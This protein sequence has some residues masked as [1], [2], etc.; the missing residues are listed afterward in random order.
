MPKKKKRGPSPPPPRR[1]KK[2]VVEDLFQEV[3]SVE[4]ELDAARSEMIAS[5]LKY[6]TAERKL[7]GGGKN[8]QRL[9]L[10]I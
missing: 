7:G 9:K 5:V 3:S 8:R 1:G 6:A 4:D 10:E 2:K